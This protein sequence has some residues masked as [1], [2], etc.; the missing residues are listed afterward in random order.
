MRNSTESHSESDLLQRP[1]NITLACLLRNHPCRDRFFVT[2]SKK[3]SIYDLELA[4]VDAQP[5]YL[6]TSG[7]TDIHIYGVSTPYNDGK[8]AEA[9]DMLGRENQK[10]GPQLR[11][12]NVFV[13]HPRKDHVHVI[14]DMDSE[15]SGESP[16]WTP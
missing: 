13:G 6:R 10:L 4:I 1:D 16:K 2:I 14:I 11:V 15:S 7:T 9:F 12:L 5:S 3:S 8:L